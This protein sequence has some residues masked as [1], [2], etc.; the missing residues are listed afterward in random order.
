[1]RKKI[2]NYDNYFIYDNGDVLN[3]STGE[4]LRSLNLDSSTISKVC[5]GINKSHGGFHFKYI[6]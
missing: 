4:I 3:I 6:E 1:M 2:P 5:R